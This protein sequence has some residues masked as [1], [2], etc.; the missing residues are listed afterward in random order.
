MNAPEDRYILFEAEAQGHDLPFAC[1]MGCCTAC[2]VKITAGTLHQPQ[3]LGISRELKEKGY[4]LLCVGLAGTDLEVTTQDEDEVYD[5]QFG[6]AFAERALDPTNAD[7]VVR[8]DFALEK[9]NMDE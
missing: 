8:D 9:A 4:A 2:A 7:S 3:A 1:R 6:Q 5:L